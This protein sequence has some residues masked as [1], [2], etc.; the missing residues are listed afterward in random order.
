MGEVCY[1]LPMLVAYCTPLCGTGCRTG[2]VLALVH[3]FP[4]Y[5][6]VYTYFWTCQIKLY[7]YISIGYWLLFFPQILKS[8]PCSRLA[9]LV[10]MPAPALPPF[11]SHRMS[12][13]K[14][15]KGHV[16]RKQINWKDLSSKIFSLS[17]N[18]KR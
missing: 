3:I 4:I 2:Y 15:Y 9:L 7:I 17:L 12:N 10:K 18:S 1:N 16:Y 11:P 6:V 13:V 8:G 5:S 14:Y